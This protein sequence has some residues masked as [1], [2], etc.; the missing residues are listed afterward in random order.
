MTDQ[1]EVHYDTALV[2]RAL[3]AY[4]RSARQLGPHEQLMQPASGAS[5]EAEFEGRNYVCICNTHGVLAVYRERN[6]G[7][8][9]RLKRWPAEL[10]FENE[11]EDDTTF[12]EGECDMSLALDDL[13][14]EIREASSKLKISEGEFVRRA[15]RAALLQKQRNEFT[16]GQDLDVKLQNERA[17]ERAAWLKQ[18]SRKRKIV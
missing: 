13:A 6:D 16:L 2:E 11:D 5:Y 14:G 9:K 17:Q 12:E 4:F 3:S 1:L 8:L 15:I 10:D 18:H 7:M